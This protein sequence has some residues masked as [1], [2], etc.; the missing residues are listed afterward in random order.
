MQVA[1]SAMTVRLQAPEIG[2]FFTE[3]VLLLVQEGR[4]HIQ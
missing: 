2:W 1:D 4:P 3:R